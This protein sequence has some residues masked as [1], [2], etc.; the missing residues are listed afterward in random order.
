[1]SKH[2]N[3]TTH[4]YNISTH[5]G[6]MRHL[7]LKQILKFSIAKCWIFSLKHW[8]VAMATLT[9]LNCTVRI[10]LATTW[11]GLPLCHLLCLHMHT[12]STNIVNKIDN[13]F[14]MH[15]IFVHLY[16]LFTKLKGPHVHIDLFLQPQFV[17]KAFHNLTYIDFC[18]Y[19]YCSVRIR[20]LTRTNYSRTLTTTSTITPP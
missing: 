18:I 3:L 7:A 11:H 5:I 15:D 17:I 16:I 14:Y 4:S 10:R 8:H 13:L 2:F 1:M 19:L 12:L 20:E 9:R 6:H